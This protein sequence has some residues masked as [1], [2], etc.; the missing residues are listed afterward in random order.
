MSNP[1]KALRFSPVSEMRGFNYRNKPS[2][3]TMGTTAVG[4]SAANGQGAKAYSRTA[5]RP[6]PSK[7][8]FYK[9]G[10]FEGSQGRAARIQATQEA[11]AA[12]EMRRRGTDPRAW[13]NALAA[14]M[15]AEGNNA[16]TATGLRHRAVGNRALAE[17]VEPNTKNNNNMQPNTLCK[18]VCNTL[19]RCFCLRRGGK[20][21]RKHYKKQKSYTRKRHTRRR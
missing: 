5:A 17:E 6:D 9:E 7:T 8:L 4:T 2:K 11:Y 3:F 13:A 10:A 20:S 19:G 18:R 1:N 12:G 15:S 14:E 16:Y 21:T